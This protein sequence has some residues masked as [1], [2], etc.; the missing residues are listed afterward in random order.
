VSEIGLGGGGGGGERVGIPRADVPLLARVRG[1]FSHVVLAFIKTSRSASPP[2][3]RRPS[4]DPQPRTP[5]RP[6]KPRRLYL[7]TSAPAGINGSASKSIFI[8]RILMYAAIQ[9][10]SLLPS[11]A[12]PPATS[13]PRRPPRPCRRRHRQ[14][15][16]HRLTRASLLAGRILP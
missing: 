9:F 8:C 3:Q 5:R 7:T 16:Q 15:R 4:H 1:L 2:P 6:A 10:A 12:Y 11:L 14:H 13:R